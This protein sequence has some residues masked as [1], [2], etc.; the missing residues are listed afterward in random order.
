[1][2]SPPNQNCPSASTSLFVVARNFA[3][4]K[5]RIKLPLSTPPRAESRQDSPPHASS[6]EKNSPTTISS[7]SKPRAASLPNFAIPPPSSSSTTIPAAPLSAPR[8]PTLTSKRSPAI[9][10][11]PLA[12]FSPSIGSSTPPPLKKSPS[13]SSNASQLPA[14]TKRL[15]LFLRLR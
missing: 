14:S 15:W 9:P 11:P 8:S 4:A 7:T 10:F 5:I 2:N 12:A 6:K 13:S 1:S 3:T